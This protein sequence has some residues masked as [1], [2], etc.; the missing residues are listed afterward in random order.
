MLSNLA[1]TFKTFKILKFGWSGYVS[2]VI[3]KT[4]DVL[5]KMENNEVLQIRQD[6]N[7]LMLD[8]AEAIN[9]KQILMAEAGV[10]IGKSYAY[11]IPGLLNTNLN[12]RLP[13]VIST[14]SIQ[15]TEQLQ[16][17]V[18]DVSRLIGTHYS[19]IVGK[20]RTNYPCFKRYIQIQ[21][22][23]FIDD[24][25]KSWQQDSINSKKRYCVE[26]CLHRRCEYHQSCEFHN[27]RQA[28]SGRTVKNCIIVNHNLLLE[29][30]KKKRDYQ[31]E[32][33]STAHTIII[34]EAHKFEEI[35]R[36]SLSE[37]F[38]LKDIKTIER[39]QSH[40]NFNQGKSLKV[41]S[42]L[43]SIMKKLHQFL[44]EENLE[45]IEDLPNIRLNLVP[46]SKKYAIELNELINEIEEAIEDL[47]YF[48]Y[49]DHLDDIYGEFNQL[50]IKNRRIF[51]GLITNEVLIWGIY[52]KKPEEKNFSVITS[53]KRIDF[54]LKDL[55][56]DPVLEGYSTA[57]SIVFLSATLGSGDYKDT[58]KYYAY[59]QKSLGLPLETVYSE[60]KFSPFNYQNQTILY[61]PQEEINIKDSGSSPKIALEIVRLANLTLGRTMV[62]FTSKKQLIEIEQEL[63]NLQYMYN[64]ALLKQSDNV[65]QTIAE[66][67]KTKGVLLATG[68]F[69]EGINI[70][71][72]DL[73]SLIIVRLPYPVPTDPVN[74]F[75]NSIN[76]GTYRSEMLIKLKQGAGRLIRKEKDIGILT[77]LD[78]RTNQ[79][80]L[81]E[82]PYSNITNEFDQVKAFWINKNL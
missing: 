47:K 1:T 3:S 27:M 52:D 55:L 60:P 57:E 66:F 67:L 59:Q 44:I 39:L 48:D 7:D 21:K 15:L 4:F 10:G 26:K 62:L 50:F 73:S 75:K 65:N 51:K 5:E 64:W 82:L 28:I 2:E 23:S 40:L 63:L 77:I 49:E 41:T 35:A 20:G 13:L 18:I 25:E 69:W 8:I 78:G 36:D 6:Q 80:I 81:K 17:D 74:E 68:A 43:Y 9:N 37:S 53:P 38:N 76:K 72:S 70:P 33:I 46:F 54:E 14:S 11:L 56:F 32:L 42:S 24:M 58:D 30:L 16:R 31:P 22:D 34:D 71:G 79:S 45:E 19:V 12:E 29:S 61:T